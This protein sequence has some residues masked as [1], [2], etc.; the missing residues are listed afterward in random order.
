M[1]FGGKGPGDATAGVIEWD[2][3]GWSNA[4]A[5]VDPE[6]DAQ[7]IARQTPGAAFDEVNN[8]AVIFGGLVADPFTW[9]LHS[10]AVHSVAHQF[11]FTFAAAGAPAGV[12]FASVDVDT[13]AG[14]SGPAGSL[15]VWDSGWHTLVTGPLDGAARL[16]SDDDEIRRWLANPS[17]TL[18]LAVRSPVGAE[19]LETDA[20]AATIRYRLP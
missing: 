15:L 1:A 10:S 12:T 9:L 18:H 5:V 16:S 7:P 17:S 20:I 11:D 8:V 6:G 14:A 13:S 19:R 3:V 4:R 2:G